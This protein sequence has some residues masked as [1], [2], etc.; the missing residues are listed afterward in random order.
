VVFWPVAMDAKYKD[1]EAM[2]DG[3]ITLCL[4]NGSIRNDENAEMAYLLRRKSKIMV[5]FGS[6]ACEGCIPGLANLHSKEQL[7]DTVYGT[8]TTD[9]N[10]ASRP[11]IHFEAAEGVIEIPFLYDSVKTLSQVVRVDYFMPGCPP[12]S[13]RIGEVVGLVI[14][15][16]HGE[17]ELPPAGS[18]IGAGNS[19]VCDECERGRTEKTITAFRRTATYQPIPGECLL[20]Q[21]ILCSGLATRSG[22]GAR[23]PAANMPCIGCYGAAPDVVDQGARMLSAVASVVGSDDPAEIRRI[24]EGIVDPVGTFYRFSLP[25]SLLHRARR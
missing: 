16:L 12:E 5:A 25:A 23:C 1:V 15:A 6:C 17:A 3:A 10:G 2:E 9:S 19:T 13:N 22:C 21:G 24:L 4:F 11:Q 8:P 18:V 20:E 7:L 14:K